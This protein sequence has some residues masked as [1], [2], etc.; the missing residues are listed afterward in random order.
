M[1]TK[2]AMLVLINGTGGGVKVCQVAGS[3]GDPVEW[4]RVADGDSVPTVMS[5]GEM[6]LPNTL[7]S[8]WESYSIGYA[9]GDI[10]EFD[11]WELGYAGPATPLPPDANPTGLMEPDWMT[12]MLRAQQAALVEAGQTGTAK[13]AEPKAKRRTKKEIAA[14]E[15]T[16][17]A[18][19]ETITAWDGRE[20]H[21]TWEYPPNSKGEG[22]VTDVEGFQLRMNSQ[23]GE[24]RGKRRGVL[25]TG[26]PGTGKSYMAYM[27]FTLG[28]EGPGGEPEVIDFSGGDDSGRVLGIP[29]WTVERG[30][31]VDLAA[32]TR[33]MSHHHGKKCVKNCAR[34]KV[35]AN[36][37]NLLP[38]AMQPLFHPILEAPSYAVLDDG[39]RIDASPGF[40]IGGSINVYAGQLEP[41]FASRFGRP[42]YRGIDW[43]V[44]GR[45]GIDEDAIT[46]ARLLHQ[47]K[48]DNELDGMPPGIR[49]LLSVTETMRG[50]SM[51]HGG[52]MLP[53]QARELAFQGF[54]GEDIDPMDADK[55]RESVLSAVG[56]KMDL[57][58]V[59]MGGSGS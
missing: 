46:V 55:I 30:N 34:D 47:A 58:E 50:F 4:L 14:A 42:V 39:Q 51:E 10:T 33:A 22:G 29:G 3:A 9:L 19:M 27:V 12:L 24:G 7:G 32:V 37:L 45:L 48:K 16:L 8:G 6:F 2:T 36:E 15:K 13:V 40:F 54:L 49:E 57:P 11:S 28:Q 23:L 59:G 21:P 38:P 20:L 41:A 56:V 25:Q 26:P 31:Y 17:A 1:T 35:V 18:R 44:V 43:D 52:P 5:A 53:E